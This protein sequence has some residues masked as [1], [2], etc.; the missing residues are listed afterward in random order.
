MSSQEVRGSLPVQPRV[1]RRP[2]TTEESD[3]LV[4]S[5]ESNMGWEEISNVFPGRSLPA[6]KNQYFQLRNLRDGYQEAKN[7][8]ALLYTRRKEDM[9]SP[10]AAEIAATWR[11]VESLHW[12]LGQAEMEKRGRDASFRTTRVSRVNLPPPQVG[13]QQGGNNPRPEWS[14]DEEAFLFACREDDGAQT[15]S[16]PE[17]P[18]ERKNKL[19]KL[20]ESHKASMWA[21]IGDALNIPWKIAEKLHWLLGKN[22][23]TERAGAFGLAPPD[24]DNDEVHQ[25]SDEEPAQSSHHLQ[26][27]QHQTEPAPMAREGQPGSLLTSTVPD[28]FEFQAGVERLHRQAQRDT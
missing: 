27:P 13:Q 26:Y 8:L 15:A 16:G 7:E 23:M 20:Y 17:W 6:C 12:S 18:Q 19:C 4:R 14:G 24:E 10:I 22:G 1:P 11:E 2:W 28:I 21:P 9:W 5:K 25:H 3:L